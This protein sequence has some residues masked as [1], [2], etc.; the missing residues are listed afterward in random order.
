[1]NVMKTLDWDLRRWFAAAGVCLTAA[2]LVFSLHGR[3]LDHLAAL[4]QA[5]YEAHSQHV[6]ERFAEW[7]TPV[8][9]T[10]TGEVPDFLINTSVASAADV[11][12]FVSFDFA[13][14]EK[15]K[16]RAD[17]RRCLSEAIYYE[18]L[19]EPMIGKLGVADVVLNRV[20]SPL[21]PD[22]ICGVVYQGSERQTGCQFS[23]TCDGSMNRSRNL[24]KYE[25]IEEIAGAILAGVHIP[26]SRDA[27]HYHANYVNPYWAPNLT[28]TTVIGAHLFYRFP[29][30]DPVSA[31]Q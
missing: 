25:E 29:D 6:A 9:L 8:S 19:G 31:A 27:T 11:S 12:D 1:M 24:A 16:I 30:K 15:A 13:D 17:E 3:W 7:M 18:S 26:V 4:E 22:S 20:E 5:R 10:E 23:F 14:L 28:R 21:Y 2:L